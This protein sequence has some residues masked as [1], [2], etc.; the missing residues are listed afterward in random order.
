[1][2]TDQN[3]PSGLLASLA[4]SSG[5]R[6]LLIRHSD[7]HNI[8]D[9]SSGTTTTLTTTGE[10]RAQAL[11]VALGYPPVWGISSP[12][13]RCIQTAKLLGSEPEPSSILGEPGPFVTDR[14]LGAKIFGEFGTPHVVFGQIKGE[15]WGCMRSLE[16]GSKL[17]FTLL[18]RHIALI[19]GTGIAVS[20]DA[21]IM[22]FISWATGYDFT[23]D[24]LE[25]LDG[26]IV[27]RDAI[28]WRGVRY[29]VKQ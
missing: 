22:P 24:W 7:R 15:T 11:A 2:M 12:L 28:F 6:A 27:R 3:L 21:I 9:G 5:C 1:M 16:E 8:P 14:K 29:E 17:L 20:H 4:A 10:E 26:V 23:N 18:T 19:S 25:P 13:L